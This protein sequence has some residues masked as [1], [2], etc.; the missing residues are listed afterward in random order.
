MEQPAG[1]LTQAEELLVHLAGFVE[2]YS[3]FWSLCLVSRAFYRVF[4]GYLWEEIV[5][6]N[7]N[8][9]FFSDTDRLALFLHAHGDDL[10]RAPS[11]RG[12]KSS[13]ASTLT[14]QG[15]SSYLA[16]MESLQLHMPNLKSYE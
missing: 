10:V 12:V 8:D 7:R 2:D 4:R 15:G 14:G 3:T 1:K 6:D 13:E 9:G 16:G 5:W 11:L